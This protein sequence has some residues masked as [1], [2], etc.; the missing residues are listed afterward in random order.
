MLYLLVS[1]K[2]EDGKVIIK[3]FYDNIKLDKGMCVILVVVFDNV[4]MINN[5]IGIVKLE[6]V[7]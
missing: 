7:G 1:M 2:S 6:S 4:G 5:C 3:G